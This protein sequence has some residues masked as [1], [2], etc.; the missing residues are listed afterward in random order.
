MESYS[1]DDVKRKKRKI[2]TFKNIPDPI[3]DDSKD[4]NSFNIII[5]KERKILLWFGRNHDN[6]AKSEKIKL[7]LELCNQFEPEYT[8]NI[9]NQGEETPEFTRLLYSGFKKKERSQLKKN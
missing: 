2:D 6:R 5:E 1:S 8:L 4:D 3:K 9:V 7:M